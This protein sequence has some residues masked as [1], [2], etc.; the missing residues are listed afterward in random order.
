[1]CYAKYLPDVHLFWTQLFA[2]DFWRHP[3]V[4]ANKGHLDADFV[5]RP[6]RSKVADFDHII[7]SKQDAI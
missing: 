4:G 2:D 5:P 3:G 7:L 1:M 6:T